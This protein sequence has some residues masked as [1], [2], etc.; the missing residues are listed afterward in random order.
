MSK[1]LKCKLPKP[2]RKKRKKWWNWS[3]VKTI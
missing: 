2:V 3:G 1:V